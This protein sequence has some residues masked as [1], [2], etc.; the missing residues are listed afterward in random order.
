MHSIV[1]PLIDLLP[2]RPLA[3]WS[4]RM[5]HMGSGLAVCRVFESRSW[6]PLLHVSPLLSFPLSCLSS[7]CTIN[8]GKKAQNKSL[9]KK[10]TFEDHCAKEEG[11]CICLPV[12]YFC[13]KPNSNHLNCTFDTIF[14]LCVC[15][16]LWVHML[17]HQQ[18]AAVY[19][20]VYTLQTNCCY[21][22]WVC[23][24]YNSGIPYGFLLLCERLSSRQ[25]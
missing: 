18:V 21:F 22:G 13:N 17:Q 11:Y 20:F 24:H 4:G 14:S 3:Y 15:T 12:R 8:K 6:R 9:K 16:C 1:V 23:E 10:K 2:G 5:P 19:C 25:C 7:L